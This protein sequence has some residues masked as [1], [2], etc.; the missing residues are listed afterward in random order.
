VVGIPET[1]WNDCTWPA[2]AD[3]LGIDRQ[4]VS[5]TAVARA[6]GSVESAAIVG[7]TGHGFGAALLACARRHGLVP[8]LDRGG[9]PVRAR[10]GLIRFTFTRD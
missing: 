6:D 10:S 2:D 9:H 5:M 1:E 4:V 3:T 7:D 8:A